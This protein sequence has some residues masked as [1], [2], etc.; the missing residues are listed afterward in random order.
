MEEAAEDQ[1]H[2]VVD[3]HTLLHVL[4]LCWGLG[5]WG[6]RVQGL[7]FR[8]WGFVELRFNVCHPQVVIGVE[9]LG[10][11]FTYSCRFAAATRPKP[12]YEAFYMG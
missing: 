1:N 6:F 12:W 5:V 2:L 3:N 11:W 8:D 10:F 7:G 4:I 9:D